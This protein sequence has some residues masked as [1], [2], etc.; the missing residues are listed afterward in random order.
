MDVEFMVVGAVTLVGLAVM[1]VRYVREGRDLASGKA[2]WLRRWDGWQPQDGWDDGSTH[3]GGHHS[4]THHGGHHSGTHHGTHHSGTGH[5]DG[6]G[7]GGGHGGGFG[8]GH[9]GGHGG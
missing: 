6:G 3:H 8:G 9:G 1:V 7:F 5:H 2:G 4:G